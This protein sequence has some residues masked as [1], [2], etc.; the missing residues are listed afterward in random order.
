MIIFNYYYLRRMTL[1]IEI[2]WADEVTKKFKNL[3]EKDLK[4]ATD[5]WLK[6]S[7]ILIEWEAK[8]EVPVDNGNLRKSIKSAVYPDYAVVYTNI[9]YAPFVHEWTK[10]HLI[11]PVRKKALF[12]IDKEW[13][14]HFATLV[15]HPWYKWNPFFTRAAENK[16]ERIVNR[17]YEII[18][19]YIND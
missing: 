12:W 6:E 5:K 17:F 15:H 11:R 9:F 19:E 1:S 10:P 13:M 18:N 8:K 7:A 2:R 14:G 4:A 3:S 16:S